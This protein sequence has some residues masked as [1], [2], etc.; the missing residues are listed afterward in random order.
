M[1][2]FGLLYALALAIEKESRGYPKEFGWLRGQKL[3]SSESVCANLTEGFYS[4]Y[5]TEYLQSLFRCRREARET[6]TH[7]T[8]ARDVGVLAKSIA[9]HLLSQY[10]DG[11]V[12]INQLIASVERKIATYGKGKPAVCVGETGE[13][14]WTDGRHF[15]EPS[16]IPPEPSTILS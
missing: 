6:Q 9:D 3:R 12:Q 1:P 4:Q 10:E 13:G 14:Y 16:T 15:P 11:L 2:V 7:L 8:Y 5:S